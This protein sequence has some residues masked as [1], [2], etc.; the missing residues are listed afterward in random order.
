MAGK[1]AEARRP[2]LDL[3]QVEL[4]EIRSIDFGA[5][6]EALI[7]IPLPSFGSTNSYVDI[8]GDLVDASWALEKIAEHVES[9]T[10]EQSERRYSAV[11]HRPRPGLPEA[12]RDVTL[13]LNDDYDGD[14]DATG[15]RIQDLRSEVYDFEDGLNERVFRVPEVIDTYYANLRSAYHEYKSE[16]PQLYVE[17]MQAHPERRVGFY[18]SAFSERVGGLAF[19]SP[20]AWLLSDDIDADRF[21]Q[22]TDQAYRLDRFLLGEILSVGSRPLVLAAGMVVGFP[23]G[24]FFRS[25][26]CSGLVLRDEDGLPKLDL[27][28]EGGPIRTPYGIR[29]REE[30]PPFGELCYVHDT[31]TLLIVTAGSWQHVLYGTKPLTMPTVKALAEKSADLTQKLSAS[32]G[33]ADPVACDWDSLDDDRFE[34]LCYDLIYANPKF[35]NDTIRKLGKSRSRDGGRDIEVLECRSFPGAETRKWIFQCKLVKGGRSLGRSGV[36]D[37]GDMLDQYGAQGFGVMTSSLIDAGLYDKLSAVCRSRDVHEYHFS[38][39][40]LERTLARSPAI[41]KRYF[42]SR[43]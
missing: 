36:I 18:S 14:D 41:R 24:A 28:E 27:F 16:A 23:T 43:P 11:L 12:L 20:D 34:T 35:D 32:I 22:Q 5:I 25:Q 17:H 38:V 4:E 33:L 1:R 42:G 31:G 15:A 21:F 29:E 10:V 3:A 8:C 37:V 2:E 19:A 40:E 9:I 7:H 6:E 30:R 13:L 26:V 39:L